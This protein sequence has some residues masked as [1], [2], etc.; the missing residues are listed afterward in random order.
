MNERDYIARGDLDGLDRART[1]AGKASCRRLLSAFVAIR[2]RT[3]ELTEQVHQVFLTRGVYLW[4]MERVTGDRATKT[5]FVYPMRPGHLFFPDAETPPSWALSQKRKCARFIDGEPHIWSYR[6]GKWAKLI[7]GLGAIG[8]HLRRNLNSL[9]QFE[10]TF[11]EPYEHVLDLGTVVADDTYQ[12]VE[13]RLSNE[14]QAQ[15]GG[16]SI[17]EVG[18]HIAIRNLTAEPA[19]HQGLIYTE[20]GYFGIDALHERV[21]HGAQLRAFRGDTVDRATTHVWPAMMAVVGA[22]GRAGVATVIRP[23]PGVW[24]AVGFEVLYQ[25]IPIGDYAISTHVICYFG[26]GYSPFSNGSF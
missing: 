8:R 19:N 3:D 22:R 14:D 1:R 10:H 2:A 7:R 17:Q 13:R 16:L 20:E 9:E 12:H 6:T 23:A 24:D 26:Q 15:F 25:G 21:V 18:V 11:G 5:R 4:P